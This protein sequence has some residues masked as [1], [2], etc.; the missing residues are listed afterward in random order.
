M[1]KQ[2]LG[3]AI[4]MGLY[5]PLCTGISVTIHRLIHRTPQESSK[6][7]IVYR[8][9]EKQSFDTANTKSIFKLDKS[10]NFPFSKDVLKAKSLNFSK[11]L[12]PAYVRDNSL[13]QN[14]NLNK[15]AIAESKINLQKPSQQQKP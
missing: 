6:I 10:Q 12:S 9:F 4:F 8:Q 7:I 15:I 1:D 3:M 13:L 5:V 2:A 14:F 11:F